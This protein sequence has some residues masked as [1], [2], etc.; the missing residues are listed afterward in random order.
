MRWPMAM[1]QLAPQTAS[2]CHE[3]QQKDRQIFALNGLCLGSWSWK[4]SCAIKG[5]MVDDVHSICRHYW[6]VRSNSVRE[7]NQLQEVA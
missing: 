3:C 2:G 1:E 7:D 6:W 4:D 5:H